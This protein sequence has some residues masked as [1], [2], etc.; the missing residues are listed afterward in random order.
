MRF[1]VIWRVSGKFRV[2]FG[3]LIFLVLLVALHTWLIALIGHG[4]DPLGE[5]NYDVFAPPSTAHIL[6]TDRFGRDFLAVVLAS[7]PNSMLVALIAGVVSTI[8]GVLVGFVAG[9]EGGKIDA[10]LRTI[11]DVFLVI[12]TLPL[13]LALAAYAKH[14]TLPEVALML[15]IFSW[16]FPARTIRSQVLSLRERPYVELA[17]LSK[18]SDLKIIFKQLVPNL[19][20][21]IG[22]GFAS[23]ALG[24]IFALVGLEVIGLGPSN[25]LDLGLLINLSINWGVLSLG[26]WPIFVAPIVLLVLLFM[27]LNLMNVGL[28]EFFNPRLRRLTEG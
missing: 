17:K 20:P 27:S 1:L 2:G 26:A 21:Y 6:G 10:V 22:V 15:S 14:V 12:P 28:E 19:L 4:T 8:I 7:L 3:I 11:T 9:Y 23:A 24:A 13:L 5:G 25:S 18:E 16:P